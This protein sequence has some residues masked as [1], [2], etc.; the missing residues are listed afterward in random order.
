MRCSIHHFTPVLFGVDEGSYGSC[1]DVE[2]DRA[3]CNPPNSWNAC[4]TPSGRVMTPQR[5]RMGRTTVTAVTLGACGWRT[6]DGIKGELVSQYVATYR[7]IA[8]TNPSVKYCGSLAVRVMCS[9]VLTSS[10]TLFTVHA[11][12]PGTYLRC[13]PGGNPARAAAPSHSRS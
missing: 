13:M 9:A 11:H 1:V 7:P 3:K 4:V 2:Y 10:Y 8:S 12:D 5:R 6:Y